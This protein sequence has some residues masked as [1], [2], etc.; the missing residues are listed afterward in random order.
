MQPNLILIAGPNGAGKTTAAEDLLQGALTVDEF[1]NADS[2]ARGLSRFRPEGVAMEA[3]RAM[4][5]RLQIVTR[6]RLN[7]AFESTLASRTFA[8]WI[9]GLV[10]GGYTFHLLYFW[11]PSPQMA[12]DRVNERAVLGG[13]FVSE[14]IVH[15]R[16]HAGLRNFFS[17]YAPMAQTWTFFDNAAKPRAVIASGGVGLAD[18]VFNRA[19]WDSIRKEY[20][21]G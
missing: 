3:G 12:F 5:Q 18:S 6:Q 15:R 9:R 14:A 2:V 17:L 1:V 10:Q 16:Y 8:P 11:L 4:I 20:S 21:R 19:V 13:H 7:V